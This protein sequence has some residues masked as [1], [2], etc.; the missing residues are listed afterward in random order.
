MAIVGDSLKHELK[1]GGVAPPKKRYA[2]A[3]LEHLVRNRIVTEKNA[4]EASDYIQDQKGN[5]KRR[6]IDILTEE[7]AISKDVLARELAQ[8]YS[9]RIVDINERS[10]RR[11]D[12]QT[13]MKLID[14]LA[15][16]AY[17]LAMR[18]KILPYET[19]EGQ[20]DK[21]LV[22]TPNPTD[23]EAS[24]VARAF[25][26]AKH[27]ICYMKESDWDEFW[28]LIS[29]EKSANV[30]GVTSANDSFFEESDAELD[31]ALD[32]EIDSSQLINL[33]NN[34]FNDAVRVGA[35]DIHFIPKGARKTEISFRIDGQ[36]TPW[37]TI[38]DTRAEAVIAVVK[39]RGVGLD[40][41][42]RMAA[43]DG[44]AQKVIDDQ[45]IR[46]RMSVLPII[47]K[48]MAGQFESVVIRILKDAN[49]SVTLESIGLDPYSL[50]MFREAINKP[51]GIVILT[52][53]TGSGKSTTLVAALRSVM[54]PSLCTITVEDPV[55]YL[56]EGARQVKLNHKL[57]FDD[58]IRA[59]LR[60]DPDIIMVGEIRDRATADIA[61]KL[62]NTGHL[63]FSTLH[64]NDAATVVSRLFKIGVEPFL[65]AQALNIVVAQRLVR[66]L[67]EKCKR[68]IN[69]KGLNTAFLLKSGFTKEEIP[70]LQLFEPVG[71]VHCV[72]GYKGRRAI[73]ET[74]YVSPEIREIIIDSGD[75]I[76]TD[77]IY[78]AAMKH[79]MRTLRRS[80][81]E[82]AEQ[83]LSSVDEV[84][85]ATTID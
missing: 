76:D 39:G 30:P 19:A 1:F 7:F 33:V 75:K 82:L 65:I 38:E 34:I 45:V 80:G 29:T 55:E 49:A 23:R 27:E 36:L 68:L 14:G 18:H 9:F 53:P 47:S 5:E 85:G 22:V 40:R 54:N 84:V 24:E 6:I 42:E 61:I 69:P 51:H 77:A 44:Q 3:F 81:L 10:L 4:A 2:S 57:S 12:N 17:R 16:P 67:C 64:T 58:A 79:G 37:Y 35:S 46:F 52:G 74:L 21:L 25:P 8:F 70:N 11:L 72:G 31:S 15:G 73:H 60:H 26:Y 56:L 13:I 32:R 71:C 62:A 63:T 48:E 43:Q 66:K 20:S 50:E 28:Q 59:I 83:G 78:K 41:F